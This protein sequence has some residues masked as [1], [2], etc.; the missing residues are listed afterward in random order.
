MA[1]VNISLD[2]STRQVAL[3]VNGVLVPCSE[4]SLNK[5]TYDGETFVEFRY[6]SESVNAEGFKTLHQVFLPSNEELASLASENLD[7]NGF[8]TKALY[9]SEKAKADVVEFLKSKRAKK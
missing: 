6:I 1:I 3:A 4:C 9:D 8:A 7:E 5:Y 2:T